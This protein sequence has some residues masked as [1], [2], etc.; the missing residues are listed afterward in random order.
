MLA[1]DFNILI[2]ISLYL[3]SQLKSSIVHS[4]KW[5]MIQQISTVFLLIH[6]WW[7]NI[8]IY[9]YYVNFLT[10][11]SNFLMCIYLSHMSESEMMPIQM[12]KKFKSS[13]IKLSWQQRQQSSKNKKSFKI[14]FELMIIFF[15]IWFEDIHS[16]QRSDIFLLYSCRHGSFVIFEFFLLDVI[17]TI[18]WEEIFILI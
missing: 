11:C 4:H 9:L 13:R 7:W 18:H 2:I 16:G 5:V 3:A 6:P 1:G 12:H 17:I 8:Y 14:D 10:M 15:F